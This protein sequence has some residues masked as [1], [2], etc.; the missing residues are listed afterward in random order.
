MIHAML[1][2]T[3]MSAGEPAADAGDAKERIAVLTPAQV[4]KRME[5]GRLDWNDEVVVT[6]WVGAVGTSPVIGVDGQPYENVVLAPVSQTF[7]SPPFTV[8]LE[9]AAQAALKR[10]GIEDFAEHFT[11]K[12]IKV[13]GRITTVSLNLIGSPQRNFY[14]LPIDDLDQFIHVRATDRKE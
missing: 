1:L 3:A 14:Q 12:K 10:L 8:V 9:P 7:P 13:R 5:S 11:G 2:V 4:V 6:A